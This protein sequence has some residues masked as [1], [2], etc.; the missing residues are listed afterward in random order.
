[1]TK[2]ALGRREKPVVIKTTTKE[3]TPADDRALAKIVAKNALKPRDPGVR[4]VAG[5]MTGTSLDG[6]D[7]ALVR[8]QGFG[9]ALK[10]EFVG[11]V[12]LPLG[13]VAEPLRRL[14]EQQPMTAG[15][16]S[17]TAQDFSALHVQALRE[18]SSGQPLD[19]IAV[20]GQT[21]FHAPPLS[22]QLLNP[23]PIA[24]ALS[25][26]VVCDLRA[27]DLAAGGQGAPITPLA[28]HLLFRHRREA[29]AI[30][31]LG[32]FCNL[33]LLPGGDDV[34]LIRG[35]DVCA[36]NQ[37]LDA[38]ARLAL[39]APFDRDGA[40]A[41]R[42]KVLDRLH[43]TLVTA[44]GAQARARRSLG[45]GDELAA[46][47]ARLSERRPDADDLARTACAAV[48]T[49]IAR[50]LGPLSDGMPQR[51]ILAGGGVRNRALVAELT[52]RAQ[53]P[54]D[55]SA[56]HGIPIDAREAGAMAVL[57]VLCADRVP[58]TLPQVTGVERA[59]IAGVWVQP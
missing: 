7:A 25:A 51:V 33:T 28:D 21:I 50:A 6:L 3:S 45:T 40:A 14:A 49:V 12:S 39:N 44:L 17:R 18:L 23:T 24:Q 36:C 16:I 41:L 15:D 5:V 57:G 52:A 19:L 59:P 56:Q 54:V 22:W 13:P 47:L 27:A 30:V 8:V 34:T 37:V 11:L 46:V 20:H 58:I 4:L 43:D 29:R 32:G 26:P 10:A 55:T 42:G 35:A 48:A 31:N 2:I 9:L 53:R 1:M 38:I